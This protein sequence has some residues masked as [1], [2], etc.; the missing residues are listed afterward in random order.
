MNG[1]ILTNEANA[2]RS[3]IGGKFASPFE[4]P[5]FRHLDDNNVRYFSPKSTPPS[6]SPENE[7]L[8]ATVKCEEEQNLSSRSQ[9]SSDSGIISSPVS[10]SRRTPDKKRRI[11][12]NSREDDVGKAKAQSFFKKIKYNR[13]ECNS[14]PLQ[15]INSEMSPCSD[16]PPSSR[17]GKSVKGYSKENFGKPVSS[18]VRS[19]A[20][21][22][23]SSMKNPLMRRELKTL[24]IM[25]QKA[26]NLGIAI[27]K[28]EADRTY[29]MISSIHH[30]GAAAESK[31]FK[32]GDEI[33]RIGGRKLKDASFDEANRMLENCQ[34]VVELQIARQPNFFF[35]PDTDDSWDPK[36]TLVR[37]RSDSDIWGPKVVDCTYDVEEKSESFDCDEDLRRPRN[38]TNFGFDEAMADEPVQPI[39]QKMS[40]MLKFQVRKTFVYKVIIGFELKLFFLILGTQ[41]QSCSRDP[42]SSIIPAHRNFGKEHQAIG[43]Q[44]R[45]WRRQRQRK[46]GH[47]RK[48]HPVGWQSCG[49]GRVETGRRNSGGKRNFTRGRRTRGRIAKDQK[50]QTRKN[51]DSREKT[52]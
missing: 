5:N 1:L 3:R 19:E 37:S 22:K 44:H 25:V 30:E 9:G 12:D 39:K 36:K 7:D 43:F 26:G 23:T 50:R 31:L 18:D 46:N 45:R 2:E 32:I 29:Y 48:K 10:A 6:R 51:C 27:K 17:V 21:Q 52:R 42:P 34:G 28:C 11:D 33:V 4:S 47:L 35:N 41:V 38:Y 13:Q 24:R 14:S 8:D 15:L 16:T 20:I 40:G 49:N